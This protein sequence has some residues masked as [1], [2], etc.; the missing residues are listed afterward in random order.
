MALPKAGKSNTMATSPLNS[1]T[2]ATTGKTKQPDD[3]KNAAQINKIWQDATN[4]G[5]EAGNKMP[6]PNKPLTPASKKLI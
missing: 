3:A 4:F 1:N 2:T 5:K 6:P